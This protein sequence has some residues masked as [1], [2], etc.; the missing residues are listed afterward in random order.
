MRAR[1]RGLTPQQLVVERACFA[2][3]LLVTNDARLWDRYPEPVRQIWR[4]HLM[5]AIT[6]ILKEQ[7]EQEQ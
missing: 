4:R 5:R 2:V 7:G 6:D 3:S 1:V